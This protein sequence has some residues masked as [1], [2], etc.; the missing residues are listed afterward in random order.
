MKTRGHVNNPYL[1]KDK[2]ILA[3]HPKNDSIPGVQIIDRTCDDFDHLRD[4]YESLV[5]SI[6]MV[7]CTQRNVWA[8]QPDIWSIAAIGVDREG[9]V[10][11]IHCR[12]PHTVH[13]FINILLDLPIDLYNAMYAEG[14]PEA[15]LYFRSGEREVE[16]VGSFESRFLESDSNQQAWPVPN[17]VAAIRR[18]KP[19]EESRLRLLHHR[20]H[21]ETRGQGLRPPFSPGH[22]L[23]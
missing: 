19:S 5:Q 20:V 23:G 10:L 12:S 14:G 21:G 8:Q 2:T 9:R 11:F 7:S 22:H 1:S 15:Q 4:H 13:D 17:V 18:S 3:F 16:L 6:R